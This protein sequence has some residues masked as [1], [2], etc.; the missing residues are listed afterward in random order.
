[1]RLFVWM[2]AGGLFQS[3]DGADSWSAVDT[4][5]TLRRSTAQAGQTAMAINPSDPEHVYVGNGSVLQAE[6][7]K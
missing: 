7:S 5:E 1:M 3:D 4:G 2:H 6:L